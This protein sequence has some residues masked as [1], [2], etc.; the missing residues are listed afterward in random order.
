MFHFFFYFCFF[1]PTLP[2]GCADYTET[3]RPVAW[4]TKRDKDKPE[5]LA[6][7]ILVFNPIFLRNSSSIYMLERMYLEIHMSPSSIVYKRKIS[8]RSANREMDKRVW[9][10]SI[11]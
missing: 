11:P 3:T 2:L 7:I 10:Q 6:R 8:K 4:V 1:N 5:F 9:V